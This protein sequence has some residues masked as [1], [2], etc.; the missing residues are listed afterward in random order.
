MYSSD[1]EFMR[2]RL[3][4]METLEALDLGIPLLVYFLSCSI[5][6]PHATFVSAHSVFIM[7]IGT[8]AT[9]NTHLTYFQH[10]ASLTLLTKP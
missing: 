9:S 2:A 10:G 5:N 3:R 8:R 4:W 6:L 7:H 1:A